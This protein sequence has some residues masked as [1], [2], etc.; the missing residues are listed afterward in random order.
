V[1]IKLSSFSFARTCRTGCE[2]FRICVFCRG[3][4]LFWALYFEEVGDDTCYEMLSD[5]NL[6]IVEMLL[7]EGP[8]VTTMNPTAAFFRD[9]SIME[10]LVALWKSDKLVNDG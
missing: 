10:M 6:T 9:G 7:K 2:P 4:A 3:P 8:E 5:R 1:P